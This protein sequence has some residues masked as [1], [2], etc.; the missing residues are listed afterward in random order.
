MTAPASGASALPLGRRRGGPADG[1]ELGRSSRRGGAATA[2][3]VRQDRGGRV[4]K[5]ISRRDR[6]AAQMADLKV[7]V[8]LEALAEVLRPGGVAGRSPGGRTPQ[9]AAPDADPSVAAGGR[10]D[11]LLAGD[12]ERDHAVLPTDRSARATR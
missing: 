1:T 5:P 12:P 9:A 10:R 11:R 7:P 2:G 8:A 3:R 4:V 6:I